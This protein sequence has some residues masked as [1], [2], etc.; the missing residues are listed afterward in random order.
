M[1]PIEPPAVALAIEPDTDLLAKAVVKATEPPEPA[2]PE[3]TLKALLFVS[4]VSLVQ[5]VGADVC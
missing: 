2:E 5:P 3:T 1:L 4:L